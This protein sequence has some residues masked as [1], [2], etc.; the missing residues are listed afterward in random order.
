VS[1]KKNHVLVGRSFSSADEIPRTALEKFQHM[2]GRQARALAQA[3]IIR[4]LGESG[5]V[6]QLTEISI[7]RSDYETGKGRISLEIPFALRS[8]VTSE[9]RRRPS[10]DVMIEE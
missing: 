5:K 2:T 7:T 4:Q 10:W 6:W 8:F 3:G 1:N 9:I